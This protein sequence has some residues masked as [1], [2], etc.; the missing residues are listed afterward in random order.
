MQKECLDPEFVIGETA[1]NLRLSKNELFEKQPDFD[2]SDHKEALLRVGEAL[3]NIP[4]DVCLKDWQQR[5]TIPLWIGNHGPLNSFL[6]E[7]LDRAW[8]VNAEDEFEDEREERK[9]KELHDK[10]KR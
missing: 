9:L 2:I 1:S 3:F 10:M 8:R 7:S 4:D 6:D 5:E